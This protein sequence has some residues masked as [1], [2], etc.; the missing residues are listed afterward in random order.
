MT[1]QV[2]EALIAPQR[3][4][5]WIDTAFFVPV[6][7]LES[8]VGRLPTLGVREDLQT[9][10]RDARVEQQAAVRLLRGTPPNARPG[11]VDVWRVPLRLRPVA[12]IAR[13]DDGQVGLERSDFADFLGQPDQRGG[14][15]SL[16]RQMLAAT[17]ARLVRLSPQQREQ[18][19]LQ[20]C[21]LR[22]LAK[23]VAAPNGWD[24]E[25]W[26][27]D[28]QL[29]AAGTR[30]SVPN[31]SADGQDLPSTVD[32]YLNEQASALTCVV[33]PAFRR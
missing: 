10:L 4:K 21:E 29:W 28:V 3:V 31:L 12:R 33:P 6:R 16:G 8:L 5:D 27:A 26:L 20:A 25:T 15:D 2:S 1:R 32:V 14:L 7:S 13:D 19:H 24:K 30:I 22:I 9:W 23:T 11:G 18:C 17:L